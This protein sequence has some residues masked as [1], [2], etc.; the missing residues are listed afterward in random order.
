MRNHRYRHARRAAPAFRSFACAPIVLANP[1]SAG[2][3]IQQGIFSLC[4]AGTPA[5]DPDTIWRAWS[6]AP[7]IVLPIVI[8]GV[9]YAY[10]RSV[11]ATRNDPDCPTTI[12]AGFFTLGMLVLGVAV[13]SPLCRMASALAW[14]HMLQHVILVAVAPPLILLGRPG[15]ALAAALA[16]WH[17]RLRLPELAGRPLF[18]GFAYGFLIWFWHIP[19]FYQTAL[20]NQG[21]HLL[22]YGS[23]LA[24]SLVFWQGIANAVRS[25][26]ARSGLVTA[27]LL[28]TIIHTGLLGALLTFS[29]SLWYPLVSGQSGS[30]GI[31]PFEDQELAGLL[32]WVPMGM[33]YLAAGLAVVGLWLNALKAPRSA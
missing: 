32:M 31:S 29:H 16:E 12:E 30:W 18:A 11:L 9:L 3:P 23:L 4:L 19:Q 2:E 8:A 10:G 14:A 21:V 33:I 26:S 7:Q 27:S 24:A 25:P 17:P 28:G 20:V 22:M 5:M 15:A 13:L 6:F 1:A